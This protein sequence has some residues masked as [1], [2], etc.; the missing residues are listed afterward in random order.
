MALGVTDQELL[1]KLVEW[2]SDSLNFWVQSSVQLHIYNSIITHKF[3][4]ANQH[5]YDLQLH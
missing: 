5:F 3:G 4:V 1:N 2:L